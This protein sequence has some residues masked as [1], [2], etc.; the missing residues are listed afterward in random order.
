MINNGRNDIPLYST[1]AGAH[2]SHFRLREFENSD[3]FAMVHPSV[4]LSLENTRLDLCMDAKEEVCILITS[5][6]RTG[7]E[8]AKL[9]ESLGWTDE[10]GRVSRNSKHLDKYGGIAVDIVAFAKSNHRLITQRTLGAVCRRHFS[11]VNDKYSDGHVHADNRGELLD[12][13]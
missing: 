10:G 5:A 1:V 7:A 6:V 8:N 3:G 11:Y 2:M 4:L 12:N 9:A 13:A